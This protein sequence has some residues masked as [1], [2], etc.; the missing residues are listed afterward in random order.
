MF[1][2]LMLFRCAIEFLVPSAS[3]PPVEVLADIFQS[4]GS[5]VSVSDCPGTDLD[6]VLTIS[7]PLS[8]VQAAHILLIRRVTEFLV[9]QGQEYERPLQ[10]RFAQNTR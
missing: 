10:T 3:V 9:S 7:G 1:S 4:T 2:E 6:K 8:G 5:R